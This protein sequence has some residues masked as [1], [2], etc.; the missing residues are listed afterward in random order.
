MWEIFVCITKQTT[1]H[2]VLNQWRRQWMCRVWVT[3]AVVSVCFS[4]QDQGSE[5]DVGEVVLLNVFVFSSP[6]CGFTGF[7]QQKVK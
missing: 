7:E 4:M 5:E 3:E 1:K 2:T 6:M